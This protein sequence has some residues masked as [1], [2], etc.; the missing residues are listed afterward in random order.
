VLEINIADV[1]GV[2]AKIIP[3]KILTPEDAVQYLQT[4]TLE[5]E[6]YTVKEG[7]VLGSI[8]M[9]H[10]LTTKELLALNPDLTEESK[11]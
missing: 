3:S 6:L 7:D 10:D 2:E 8:A 1:S 9:N 4:G 11:K 5:K